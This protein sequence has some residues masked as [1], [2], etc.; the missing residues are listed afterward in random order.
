MA[1]NVRAAAG[2]FAD[3]GRVFVKRGGAVQNVVAMDHINFFGHIV[4]C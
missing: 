2:Q 1:E 4:F 3:G